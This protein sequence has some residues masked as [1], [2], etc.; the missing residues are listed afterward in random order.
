MTSNLLLKL[1]NNRRE[2]LIVQFNISYILGSFF[3]LE[4][5][6]FENNILLISRYKVKFIFLNKKSKFVVFFL[7]F[8]FKMPL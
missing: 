2:M 3:I 7:L 4:P 8:F 5:D 6:I 1:N